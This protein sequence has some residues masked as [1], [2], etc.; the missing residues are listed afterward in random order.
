[1]ITLSDLKVIFDALRTPVFLRNQEGYF[2]YENRAAQAF[3][4]YDQTELIQKHVNDLLAV[5]PQ[6]IAPA[7]EQFAERGYWR[8]RVPYRLKNGGL[9]QADIS[10][11]MRTLSDGT[12]LSVTFVGAMP[13]K[14]LVSDEVTMTPE[15]F[16]LN[17]AQV[18]LL[19]LLVEGFSNTQVASVLDITV[20]AVADRLQDLID[21]M[22][23]SSRT[24][25]AITAIK[26]RL[27]V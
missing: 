2:I 16:G 13:E 23:V 19:Q 20:E 17:P 9:V 7:L 15:K 4:G 14:T 3:L 1:M 25:A 22:G 26:A 11:F 12:Q 5:E 8:G 21:A 18:L 27:V 24:E 10:V 6:L